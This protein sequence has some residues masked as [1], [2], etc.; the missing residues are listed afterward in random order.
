MQVGGNRR[1]MRFQELLSPTDQSSPTRQCLW[2]RTAIPYGVF[3]P[4]T[5]QRRLVGGRIEINEPAHLIGSVDSEVR[6]LQSRHRMPDDIRFL[7]TNRIQEFAEV[8]GEI[9]GRV[10]VGRHIRAAE[11]P[12]RDPDDPMMPPQ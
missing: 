4:K 3:L 8:L 6:E 12:T 1:R 5:L 2:R 7:D 11:T 9:V 10:T